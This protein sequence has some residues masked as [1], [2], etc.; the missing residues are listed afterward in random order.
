[1]VSLLDFVKRNKNKKIEIF[2]RIRLNDLSQYNPY[3]Q[4][5]LNT[6][7]QFLSITFSLKLHKR[8]RCGKEW[9]PKLLEPFF[10]LNRDLISMTLLYFPFCGNWKI[11]NYWVIKWRF[12]K[13]SIKKKSS[14]E[15]W[16][17]DVSPEHPLKMYPT[18]SMLRTFPFEI[19]KLFEVNIWQ[20]PK[21]SK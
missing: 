13:N 15:I 7:C 6:K 9:W 2:Q 4:K 1:M 11:S 10:W 17:F 5:K 8:S 19:L 21:V 3:C 18:M 12:A 14:F 16:S 20:I